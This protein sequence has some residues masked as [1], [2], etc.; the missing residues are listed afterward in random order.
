LVGGGVLKAHY[1][2][3]C[4]NIMRNI[5]DDIIKEKERMENIKE[6]ERVNSANTKKKHR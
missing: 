4:L 6:T 2:E 1:N 5:C 3:N